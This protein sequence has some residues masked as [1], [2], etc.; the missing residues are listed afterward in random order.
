MGKPPQTLII[1]KGEDALGEFKSI[2]KNLD[3]LPNVV[4]YE[5]NRKS[6]YDSA[7]KRRV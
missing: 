1:R 7:I 6:F 3:R 2:P 4:V 5:R